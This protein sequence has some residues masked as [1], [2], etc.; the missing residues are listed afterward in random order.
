MY[1]DIESAFE[2]YAIMKDSNVPSDYIYKYFK[3]RM[4]N[5]LFNELQIYIYKTKK[6]IQK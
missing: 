5:Q 6:C 3:E 1:T 4:S 2:R